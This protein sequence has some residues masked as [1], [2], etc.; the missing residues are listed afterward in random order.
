MTKWHQPSGLSTGLVFMVNSNWTPEQAQA[1][2]E[3]LD[4]MRER[5]WIHYG[6][7][8]EKLLQEQCDTCQPMDDFDH[9]LPF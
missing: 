1:V 2:W 6:S 4:D 3:L 7:V 8:I 5:V 9:D